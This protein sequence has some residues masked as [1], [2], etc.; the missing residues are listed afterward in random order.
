M[1]EYEKKLPVTVAF[2]PQSIAMPIARVISESHLKQLHMAETEKERFVT[3]YF[4]GQ[5]EEP[6][7]GEDRLIVPS[8]KVPTYDL[9]PE[10]S[11][12]ELTEVLI[13]KIQ[14]NIYDFIIINLANPDMV[15]HTGVIPAAITACQ[16]T[17]A[18][19][20]KIVDAVLSVDGACFITADHGNV[21]EMID[22]VSGGIDTEHSTYPVPFLCVA[23]EFSGKCI[24]LPSGMLPDVAPTILAYMGI[25]VPVS[26]NGRNLLAYIQRSNN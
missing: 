1:T 12:H 15:A 14:E 9:K 16:V 23:K 13:K 11:A 7:A 25:P 10:M 24:E 8:A 2:P 5:K 17:D 4:N 20:G 19:V 6:F 26:M 22:P 21:E 18:C 3:Y